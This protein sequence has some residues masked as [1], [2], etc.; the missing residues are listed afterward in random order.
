MRYLVISGVLWGTGGLTG[1]LLRRATGLSP[2]AVA[3][4][5][6]A[7]GGALILILLLLAGRRLPRGRAAWHRIGVIGGLAALFQASYFA[8][9]A[10][11]SVSLA[12]L[13]TIGASPVL[14]LVAERLTGRRRADRW[15]LGTVGLA[16]GGLVLLVGLPSGT[17]RPAA[18]LGT[19]G[20]AL[21]AAAGFATVTLVGGRPVPGLDD[22]TTVGLGFVL[23][24]VVLL[25]LA[26][27]T[28]GLEFHPA[29][30]PLGLVAALAI[31]PTALA[32]SCYFRG[33]RSA[34]ASTAAVVA[35]LEP[36]TGAVLAAVVLG[37]RLGPAGLAGA[38]LLGGAVLLAALGRRPGGPV[39]LASGRARST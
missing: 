22:L 24:G 9:V 11:T 30:A 31:G 32:Y 17:A 10:L 25:G 28:A 16:L 20:F 36:L 37:D 15:M 1:S 35:L 12:T 6:L 23:G 14:V 26:G 4:Y 13:I 19:A 39:A 29:L 5:R 7:A 21:L 34:P 38:G 33:L 27:T 18:V 3:A 8:A 2:V